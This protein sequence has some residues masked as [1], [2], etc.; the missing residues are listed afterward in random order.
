MQFLGKCICFNE[1]LGP[2]GLGFR[3]PGSKLPGVGGFLSLLSPPLFHKDFVRS[4][5][6]TDSELACAWV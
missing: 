6:H 5:A 1:V 4:A 2:S 3:E